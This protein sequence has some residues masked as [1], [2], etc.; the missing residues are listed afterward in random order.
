M[1]LKAAKPVTF[2]QTKSPDAAVAFYRDAL[3]LA[4]AGFDGFGHVF[5]MAGA[6]LRIT[7]LADWEAGA[8]PALGWHVTDMAA[9][10]TSLKA[11]GVV[12]LIYP[13][14]GMEADGFWTAPGGKA[15]VAWLHDPDG[16]LLSLTEA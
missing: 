16:N 13:G 2:I 4:Y 7:E 8:H 10:M 5:Q 6:T 1:T 15:K 14:M 11:K 3:G 12:F 9:A